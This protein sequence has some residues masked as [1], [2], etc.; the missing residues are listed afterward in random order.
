MFD[1][2]VEERSVGL[3]LIPVKPKFCVDCVF[4]SPSEI[5]P[6]NLSLGC[7]L[8]TTTFDLVTGAQQLESCRVERVDGKSRNGQRS[9]GAEG[10]NF[11]P[12]REEG[13]K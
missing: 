6:S 3:D 8:L 13:A 1:K 12:K 11:E 5:A 4:F 7:C 2:S 9:C 10:R